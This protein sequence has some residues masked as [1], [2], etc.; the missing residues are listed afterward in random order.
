MDILNKKVKHITF[1]LGVITEVMEDKI[2][3]EFQDDIGTKAFQYP[4]GF[5]KFLEAVNPAVQ[6]DV[7]EELHIKQAEIKLEL[8]RKEKEREATIL[9]RLEEKK[10][11]SSSKKKK[12]TKRS[13]KKKS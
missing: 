11:K 4:D 2:V 3:V 12:T 13:T 5:E 10:T 1:G 9:A 6:N 7:V 8:E